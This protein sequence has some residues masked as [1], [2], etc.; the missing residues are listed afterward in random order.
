MTV[1]EAADT[2]IL[3]VYPEIT[4]L[5]AMGA[6]LDYLTRPVRSDSSRCSC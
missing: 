5:K 1:F 4:A 6:L 2:V 3:P